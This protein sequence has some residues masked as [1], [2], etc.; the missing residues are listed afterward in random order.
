ML[1]QGVDAAQR[2]ATATAVGDWDTYR[3]IRPDP[4]YTDAELDEGYAGLEAEWVELVSYGPADDGVSIDLYLG[5]IAHETR[6]HGQQTAL[7][8]VIW[9]YQPDTGTITGSS[10]R[11]NLRVLDGFV[12]PD[13]LSAAAHE[14]CAP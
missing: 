6:P 3:A 5:L 1:D 11:A 13:T 12:P 2:V 4:P 8:C 14:E 10:G 7:H 9:R